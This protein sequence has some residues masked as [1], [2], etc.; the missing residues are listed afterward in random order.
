M[1]LCKE[2][3]AGLSIIICMGEKIQNGK[4]SGH[5]EARRFGHCIGHFE[6]RAFH[7]TEEGNISCSCENNGIYFIQESLIISITRNITFKKGN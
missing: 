1:S 7:T 3:L 5:L 2:E 4:S 6:T